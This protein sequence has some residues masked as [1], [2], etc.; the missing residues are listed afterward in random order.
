MTT[1]FSNISEAPTDPILGLNDEFKRDTNPNKINLSVGVFMDDHGCVTIPKAVKK[2]EAH[3]LETQKTKTYVSMLGSASFTEQTNHLIYGDTYSEAH[4]ITGQ[5]PA[6]SGALRVG[7]EFIKSCLDGRQIRL[8]N[9]TWGNHKGIIDKTGLSHSPY[10]YYCEETKSLDFDGFIN[11][12]NAIREPQVILLHVICHNPTGVDLSPEQW[13]KVR[14]V[15]KQNTN[16]F[17]FFDCAYQGFARSLEEDIYAIRCFAQAK[18]P[19]YASV[20]LL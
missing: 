16:L 13:D 11:D 5:M 1:I 6:G 19:F 2:A 4:T 15:F 10:A 14:D 8:P 20:F 12:L 17:P 18:I 3:I 9:V 7:F